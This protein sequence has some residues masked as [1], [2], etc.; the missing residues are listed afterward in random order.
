M[1]LQIDEHALDAI[2]AGVLA[3]L[4]SQAALLPQSVA[5]T[6][7]AAVEQ[8]A[9]KPS[10]L[11]TIDLADRVITQAVLEQKLGGA[12]RV[13]FSPQ[14]VLT[15]TGRDF[16]KS[17]EIIWSRGLAS[18]RKAAGEKAAWPVLV[19]RHT[20]ALDRVL[21]DLL[22]QSSP[23]LFG[24]PDDAAQRVISEM[25]RGGME[26][27]ILFVEQVHRAACLANRSEKVKA[28]VV[29]DAGEVGMIRAQL[30]A[31]TWCL[32]PTGR[33]YFE[34]RNLVRAVIKTSET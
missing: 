27:A 17:R 7:Q 5:E 34:L 20:A 2:V 10:S 24:C 25:S 18:A 4:R 33:S 8:Q 16:L 9:V 23:E 30:R 21:A 3:R 26:R 15:P 13:R 11:E 22:P 28:V 19:V 32:D 29:R 31:N 12:R 14:A 1:S 6:K